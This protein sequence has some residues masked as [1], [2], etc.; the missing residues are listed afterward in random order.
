[1]IIKLV[2]QGPTKTQGL[3]PGNKFLDK[4]NTGVSYGLV[5]MA[6]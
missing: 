6:I 5:L 3:C 1:M 2:R 4:A